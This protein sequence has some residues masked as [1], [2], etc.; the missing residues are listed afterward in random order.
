MTLVRNPFDAGGYSLAEIKQAMNILPTLAVVTP[1]SPR[2]A[3]SVSK[4]SASA[5]SSSSNT[6]AF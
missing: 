4:G 3:S 5:R 6:R 2:S 1:A